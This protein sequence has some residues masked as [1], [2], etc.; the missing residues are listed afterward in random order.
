M[1]VELNVHP[2]QYAFGRAWV[3]AFKT[4]SRSLADQL[5]RARARE[6]I[7]AEDDFARAAFAQCARVAGRLAVELRRRGTISDGFA[8]NDLR[9]FGQADHVGNRVMDHGRVARAQLDFF[10]PTLFVE[11]N[12]HIKVLHRQF[13]FSRNLKINRHLDDQVRL[14][15]RP[16]RRVFRHRRQ[17]FVIAFRRA[18]IDPGDDSVNLFFDEP[19]VIAELE[20][21]R[22]RVG[23]PGRHRAFD[24]LFSD[25]FAP[26]PHLLI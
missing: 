11:R 15:E 16:A 1:H 25:R 5:E 10:D 6:R 14:A 12:R 13:A 3:M 26:G 18:A 21:R 20:R 8:V 22:V 17:V 9:S 7:L 23:I 2:R 19:P 24:H 4:F